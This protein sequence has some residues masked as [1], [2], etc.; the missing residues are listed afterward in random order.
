MAKLETKAEKIRP[1]NSDTKVLHKIKKIKKEFLKV[2]ILYKGEKLLI[3]KNKDIKI[4][5]N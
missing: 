1:T 4:A 2:Y 5:K 3:Q